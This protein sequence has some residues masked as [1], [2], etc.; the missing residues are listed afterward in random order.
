V[1]ELASVVVSSRE[2]NELAVKIGDILMGD[3]GSR[4]VAV[5]SPE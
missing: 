3:P 1:Q 4:E 5:K 2:L